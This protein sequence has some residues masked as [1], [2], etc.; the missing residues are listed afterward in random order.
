MEFKATDIA[1]YLNG[2]IVGDSD[3]IVS[4]VSKIEDGKPGTLAF[5][6]NPKYEHHIY[7]TEASIVLVN[8]TFDPRKTDPATLIKM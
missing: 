6:S 3:V 7:E 2:E 5:L 4:D 8:K 1:A